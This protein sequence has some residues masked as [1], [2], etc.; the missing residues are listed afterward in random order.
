MDFKQQL[1]AAIEV[2]S[3]YAGTPWIVEDHIPDALLVDTEIVDTLRWCNVVQAV[4]AHDGRFWRVTYQEPATEYQDWEPDTTV[5][6]EVVPQE[7]TV[8]V[9]VPA[10]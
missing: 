3:D 2:S 10:T 5:C 4:Y 7:K 1:E 9:Y 6:Y 8:V